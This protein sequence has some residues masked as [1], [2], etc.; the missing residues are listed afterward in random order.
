[1]PLVLQLLLS[2]WQ[3]PPE[4]R[5]LQHSESTAHEAASDT[6]TESEHTPWLQ[7]NEQQ[8]VDAAQ[9]LEP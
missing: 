3:T 4:H 6:H 8:S 5:P 7:L 9:E 1:L 2:A